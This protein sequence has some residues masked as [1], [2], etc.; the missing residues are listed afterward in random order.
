M[1]LKTNSKTDVAVDRQ[2]QK[3]SICNEMD[4]FLG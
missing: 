4:F 1:S 3:E 2:A